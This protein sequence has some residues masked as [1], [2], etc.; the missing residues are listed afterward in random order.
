MFEIGRVGK[1][2]VCIFHSWRHFAEKLRAGEK[3]SIAFCHF[4][5]NFLDGLGE[6]SGEEV[7][8][9]QWQFLNG[10]NLNLQC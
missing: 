5:S 6:G 4:F 10:A 1:P 8:V 7:D 2:I 9:E 3:Q